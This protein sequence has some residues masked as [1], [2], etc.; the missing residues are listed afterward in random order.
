[1]EKKKVLT[2][3]GSD[4]GGGAG[5]QADLKTML[6]NNTFGMSVITAITAQNTLGVRAVHDVPRAMVC[7]QMDAVFTDL[8]PDAVKIGM[9]SDVEIIEEIALGL[10]KYQPHNIVLDT[11]MVSTSG[12]ALLKPEAI[13][14]LIQKLLPLADIITPN[15]PEAEC[16][17]G[18]HITSPAEME[19]AAAIISK[20][21][22][23]AVLIKGG[24]AVSCANDLLYHNGKKH[25]L[26]G[27][28]VDTDNT[29]GTGCTLS[30]AIAAHLAKGLPLKE[31]VVGAKEYLTRALE[32]G[33]DVGNG[34][35]P[36]WHKV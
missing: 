21:T 4:S 32:A 15:I 27:R 6:A 11:V 26:Y 28:K 24:H 1:M 35:G 22:R 33:L 19:K 7:A 16:L 18:M 23:A 29:H 13:E 3:A 14:A 5:I 9:V 36:V 10:Q 8:M 17:A 2:I 12:H 20:M 31:A 30:S 25:W 34:N